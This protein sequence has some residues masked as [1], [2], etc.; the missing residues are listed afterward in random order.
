VWVIAGAQLALLL[1]VASRYGYHRDELYF[2]EAAHHLAWGYVDQP[3]F[4]PFVAWAASSLVDGSVVSL[5]VVSAFATAGTVVVAALLAR[6]LGGARYAQVLSAL[7]VATAGFVLGVGHLLSTA[8]FDFAA[9]MVLLLVSARMLRTSEPR[10]W[11]AL[12]VGAGLATYNK[13]LVVL[14]VASLAIGLL[15]DR[16]F[17][18]LR[19]RWP[20]IG[21]GTGALIALPNLV[22]QAAND[23]PQLELAEAIADRIGGENRALLVPGQLVLVGPLLAPFLVAGVWWMLQPDARRFRPFLWAWLASLVLTFASAGRPYYPLPLTVLV[24]VAGS[25]VVGRWARTPARRIGVGAL[26]ALHALGA[27]MLGLPVLPIDTFA[28]SPVAA[29]NEANGE[30]VGWPELADQVAAVVRSLPPEERETVLLLTASY[31]EAGALD[32]YGPARG[33]PEVY[34]AHNA[35]WHWRR[36]RDDDA[37]VVA[38]RYSPA[39][40]APYFRECEDVGE[41][42]NGHDVD[43]EAQGAPIVVCRGLLRGWD[44]VWPELRHYS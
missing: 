30:T 2:L 31:G 12:G 24:F 42:D 4:T 27:I 23:W 3:P 25:V 20:A 33:L 22:W 18:L 43:N 8:T 13:H 9:W 11:L 36:P 39:T 44:D 35:Y 14:L 17:E 19:S 21:A 40:L 10:W 16:R 5:R 1:L 6:E 15:V 41:V 29:V 26:V 32:R 38:V 7:V 34:S 28:D 37:T